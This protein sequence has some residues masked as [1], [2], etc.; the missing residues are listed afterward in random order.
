MATRPLA[1]SLA[2]FITAASAC[3]RAPTEDANEAG[4]ASPKGA[5]IASAESGPAGPQSQAFANSCAQLT[6]R[7]EQDKFDAALLPALCPEQTAALD[8]RMR[9]RVLASQSNPRRAVQFNQAAAEGGLDAELAAAAQLWRRQPVPMDPRPEARPP[10]ATDAVVTPVDA[11]VLQHVDQASARLVT[12]GLSGRER[13][14]ARAYLARAHLES[15]AAIGLDPS[16]PLSPLALR[17][18]GPGLNHTLIFLDAYWGTPTKRLR[19]RAASLELALLDLALAVQ[20][21][22]PRELD[23]L[24]TDALHR[25]WRYLRRGPVQQRLKAQL[26]RVGRSREGYGSD[27]RPRPGAESMAAP[28]LH[29]QRLV[30][31]GLSDLAIETAYEL[32]AARSGP[33]PTPVEN[34]TLRILEANLSGSELAHAREKLTQ[35]FANIRARGLGPEPYLLVDSPPWPSDDAVIEGMLDELESL[36][37]GDATPTAS[38]AF[39]RRHALGRAAM[40]L[41]AMPT[42]LG[43]LLADPRCPA[44]L[45]ELYA[46]GEADADAQERTRFAVDAPAP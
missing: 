45:H 41:E 26:A 14:D 29:L 24:T 42:L 12:G 11:Q 38:L 23:P 44:V 16:Q 37:E 28:S 9:R 21:S 4:A 15:I 20:H 13:V 46:P 10:S 3:G 17:L 1:L 43:P 36:P 5:P 18:A 31:S 8:A 34:D 33:G 39:A 2:L 7:A 19:G 6:E 40:Q 27:D 22:P 25:A 30:Q 32:A 35:S